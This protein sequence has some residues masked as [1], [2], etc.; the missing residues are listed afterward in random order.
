MHTK[1]GKGSTES[2]A[3]TTNVGVKSDEMALLGM[4]ESVPC[5]AP[6]AASYSAVKKAGRG[7]R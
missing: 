4:V 1:T 5:R 3:E 2:L 6:R 7:K